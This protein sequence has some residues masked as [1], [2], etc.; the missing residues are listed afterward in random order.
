MRRP[1]RTSFSELVDQNKQD[2]ERDRDMLNAI[3]QRV[4]DRQLRRL[5]KRSFSK[6]EA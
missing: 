1:F 3:E 4:E 2:L 6:K 5:K